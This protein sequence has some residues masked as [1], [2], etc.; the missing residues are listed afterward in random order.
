MLDHTDV[1]NLISDHRK[2]NY[3]SVRE[4]S[5]I[6]DFRCAANEKPNSHEHTGDSTINSHD[7]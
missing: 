7:S 4:G 5:I 2:S 6:S 3:S 1:Y